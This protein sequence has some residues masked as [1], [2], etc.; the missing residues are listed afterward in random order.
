MTKWTNEKLQK[1]QDLRDEGLTVD[2]IA[3]RL[4]LRPR[5]IRYAFERLH[6]LQ[7]QGRFNPTTSSTKKRSNNHSKPIAKRSTNTQ[8]TTSTAM[9][10][11]QAGQE[12][13][14]AFLL[15]AHGF[16]PDFW[17]VTSTTSNYW[18]STSNG[19][20][21]FQTKIKV[22]PKSFDPETIVK[23]VNS[24]IEPITLPK[25]KLRTYG[26]DET[27][28]IPLYDVHFGITTYSYISK[29]LSDVYEILLRGY[30]K[31]I[32]LIGGDYFH[33]DFMTKTQ[34]SS[35]TQLDH[36]NNEQAVTQGT[37]FFRDLIRH[38][39]DVTDQIE[40]Y[41]VPGNHDADKLYMWMKAMQEHYRDTPINF[42]VTM[43][44]RV[45]FK[46]G[47]VGVMLQ[48]GDVA[49]NRAPMLFASEFSDIWGSTKNRYIFSGHYHK[50]VTTDDD[51][52]TEFQLGTPKP[53]DNYEKRNGYTMTKRQLE[54][55]AF[56]PEHLTATYY[57]QH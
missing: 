25:S 39:Y 57:I 28:I 32:V 45:A 35:G 53:A 23:A 13:D 17:H 4:N 52:V 42:H 47:N 14:E 36:V 50:Q 1:L 27:L 7:R 30:K 2:Q 5:T 51:G 10:T 33:S 44:P 56:N 31:I 37:Q 46:L 6:Q 48:H 11:V 16:N 3:D 34:T 26:S 21:Q 41:N 8:G 20:K 9:V 15:K 55:F 19:S 22:V 24:K 49:K 38:C 54:L 12:M 29:Y 40:V 43:K 18:G